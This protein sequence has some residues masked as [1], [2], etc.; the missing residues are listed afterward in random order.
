MN[1][2]KIDTTSPLRRERNILGV[3]SSQ[4][5]GCYERPKPVHNTGIGSLV[6][7]FMECLVKRGF[8][9]GII[10][11]F[12]IDLRPFF[13]YIEQRHGMTAVTG[14]DHRHVAAYTAA[15][16]TA[17]DAGEKTFTNALDA[18]AQLSAVRLFC[19]CLHIAGEVP[20]DYG[21]S[22]PVIPYPG[23][24]SGCQSQQLERKE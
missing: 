20:E 23:P 15:V 19:L 16:R 11:G 7:L 12:C 18:N 3:F 8:E 10:L 22:V 24:V 1:Y 4:P 6:V 21:L 2:N 9:P 5:S 14:F 13:D 17:Y